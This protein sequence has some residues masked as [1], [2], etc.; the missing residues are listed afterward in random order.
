MIG[1][2]QWFTRRKY[3][4]WGVWPKTWQGWLYIAVCL[5]IFA[6]IQLVPQLPEQTRIVATFVLIIIIGADVVDVMIRMRRDE[7]ERLHE[8]VAERNAM[9][10]MIIVLAAGVAY[11]V[12]RSTVLQRF[13]IDP[14]I[15][16]ALVAGLAVKAASNIYLDR[17]E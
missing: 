12:A 11:E 13:V 1:K 7:R 5:L 3:F 17:K 8:A 14:V 2:P 6:F 9:W 10:A 16:V 15:I 4:G